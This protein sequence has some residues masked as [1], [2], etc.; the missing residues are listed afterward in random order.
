MKAMEKMHERSISLPWVEEVS[1][2]LS[3]IGPVS[4][5]D[6]K[7]DII[8]KINRAPP[9][10]R[11]KF[12]TKDYTEALIMIKKDSEVKESDVKEINDVIDYVGK[13]ADAKFT[14]S[15]FGVL[16]SLLMKKME[17]DQARMGVI[18]IIL[19]LVILS[20]ALKS[21]LRIPLALG[22]ILIAIVFATGTM[23]LLGIPSTPLTIMLTTVM[24]GLGIDYSIHFLSRYHEEKEKG[25][26]TEEA[27]HS[28]SL[29]VGESIALTTVTTMFGFLSLITMILVPVQDFGKISAIGL[30]ISAIFVIMLISAGIV[31][32]ERVIKR[33]IS[34][35]HP[36]KFPRLI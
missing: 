3:L 5:S 31:I 7:R 12:L 6:N 24:L 11:R 34:L 30:A 4:D 35:E 29:K 1:S 22:P 28:T 33:L 8:E 13:P 10:F 26:S 23:G 15:G 25:L 9:D 14:Q 18:S 32:N 21:P 36:A 27:L 20:F 19:V 2:I 17:R 16:H